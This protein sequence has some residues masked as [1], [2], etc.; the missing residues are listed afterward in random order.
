[1]L[2]DFIFSRRVMTKI[3]RAIE[4]L[5]P[6]ILADTKL[7]AAFAIFQLRLLLNL[8]ADAR[9]AVLDGEWLI[10]DD[11]IADPVRSESGRETG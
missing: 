4:M 2:R 11:I 3:N 10:V 7:L 8:R 6:S 1:L 5:L 9:I